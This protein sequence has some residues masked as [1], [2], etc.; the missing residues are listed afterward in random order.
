MDAFRHEIAVTHHL[1]DH[2]NIVK[3]LGY[4]DSPPTILLEVCS[5]G[6][7]SGYYENPEATFPWTLPLALLIAQDIASG[8]E[9]MH[10]L[11]ILHGDLKPDNVLLKYG[12]TRV[13][14]VISDFGIAMA[15]SG[16]EDVVAGFRHQKLL[17]MSMQYAS[18]EWILRFHGNMN[19]NNYV[20]KPVDIFAF[21][22]ILYEMLTCQMPWSY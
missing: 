8:L 1:R 15:L 12:Q 9:H 6:S 4:S 3:L 18:P 13:M 2:K 22:I 19:R 10:R 5:L 17:G 20:S 16:K 11:Q 7:L 14:A 21:G